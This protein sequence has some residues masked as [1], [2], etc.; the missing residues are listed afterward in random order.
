MP[1]LDIPS[2]PQPP[3]PPVNIRVILGVL[4]ILI[5][6]FMGPFRTIPAGHV[7]IRGFFGQVSSSTLPPNEIQGLFSRL[8]GAR[9][10]IVQQVLLRKIGLP[11]VVANA[12]QEKLRREQEAE[13]MK[14]IPRSS[15]SATAKPAC[16]LSSAAA[17]GRFCQVRST[18]YD[19]RST[20]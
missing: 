15:S 7:G 8:A 13:Q 4:F 6:I 2:L 9:G 11:S 19:L 10:I 16:R 20:K 12:I 14:R 1:S 3:R 18:I 17:S 5:L